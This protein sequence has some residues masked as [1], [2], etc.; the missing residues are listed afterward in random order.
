MGCTIVPKS[1]TK[2]QYVPKKDHR[3]VIQSRP[4][5]LSKPMTTMLNHCY[6]MRALNKATNLETPTLTTSKPD[7]HNTFSGSAEIILFFKCQN[8][9]KLRPFLAEFLKNYCL[10]KSKFYRI[11]ELFNF[12]FPLSLNNFIT[13]SIQ[14]LLLWAEQ[15][16]L[17][18]NFV[19]MLHDFF[20][21][22][23]F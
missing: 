19:I 18:K 1:F 20:L 21:K 13:S 17:V 6:H 7:H 3:F 16:N 11:L 4:L 8:F 12:F 9:R 10:L 23:P 15:C 2:W 5:L 14:H 22:I